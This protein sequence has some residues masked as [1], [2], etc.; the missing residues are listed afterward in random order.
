MIGDNQP[1]LIPKVR[2]ALAR[3]AS[4]AIGLALATSGCS[5][6]SVPQAAP[7]AATTALPLVVAPSSQALAAPGASPTPAAALGTIQIARLRVHL[8][9]PRSRAVALILDHA[10]VLCGGITGTGATTGSDLRFDPRSGRITSVGHLAAPVHDAGAATLRGVSY[11]F[12]G[13]RFGPGAV[14]QRVS[15]NGTS[16]IIGHL[17]VA[18][19]DLV[20][21]ALGGKVLIVGGAATTRPDRR[22]L[23][24]TDGI[25]FRTV[26]TLAIGVR[27]PAVVAVADLLYVI[28]GS[29]PT[30]D[31]RIIQAVNPRTGAVRIVGHLVHPLSHASAL[32][33]G[34]QI[35]VAG[36]RSAGSAQTAVWRFDALTGHVTRAGRLPYAVSDAASAVVDG[37]GYLIGGEGAGPLATII[38]L[39]AQ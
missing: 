7:A 1:V 3:G 4:L 15:S 28:G 18:R 5:L 8:P 31:V 33:L 6:V 35:L 22:V 2:L 20:A 9:G 12:G 17:P 14:V 11:I 38:S 27:Y 24:T 10:L 23:A 37:V 26:A 16:V 34:D 19:A 39:T 30:G 21:V 25:R 29:T 32:V 36:G 13:G